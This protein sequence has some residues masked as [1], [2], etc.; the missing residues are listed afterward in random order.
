LPTLTTTAESERRQ[1]KAH[2]HGEINIHNQH[3]GSTA[4]RC[5]F[6]EH[7]QSENLLLFSHIVKLL[8]EF[9]S[10]L[11]ADAFFP[12]RRMEKQ[13]NFSTSFFQ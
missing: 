5:S 3:K 6:S 9:L 4:K 13:Q 12:E 1:E 10:V 11:P 8:N 7:F 2:L